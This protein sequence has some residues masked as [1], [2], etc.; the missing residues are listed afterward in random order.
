MEGEHVCITWDVQDQEDSEEESVQ[1]SDQLSDTEPVTSHE[2][3]SDTE[4]C[5]SQNQDVVAGIDNEFE[6]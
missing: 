1:E 2:Q 3:P 6:M 4:S 5:L